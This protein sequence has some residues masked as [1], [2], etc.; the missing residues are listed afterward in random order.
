MARIQNLKIGRAKD[1]T[2]GWRQPRAARIAERSRDISLLKV[3][4][5]TEI[6]KGPLDGRVAV[7]TGARRG[8]GKAI[9]L[10]LSSAGAKVAL[11]DRD[12][13]GLSGVADEMTRTG[14][15]AQSFQ[16]DV[17]DEDQVSRAKAEVMARFGHVDIL[18]NNAGVII[19]KPLEEFSLEEWER[20]LTTNLTSV[21]L[22][23]RAFIPQMK[24]RG[25]GRILNMTSTMSHVSI[26]GRTAYSASKAGML[27]LTK[28]LALE[29]ASE[30]ITVVG[31]SPG[32]F[33]T[34]INMASIQDPA[35]SSEFLSRIPIGRWGTPEEVGQLARYLC[36]PEASYIT[37]TDILIDGGWTAQ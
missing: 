11:I 21:F 10:S 27:G 33:A 23:C 35:I 1:R 29:L 5:M 16:A 25:Y 6:D 7:I 22:M 20:V 28:A 15:E 17:T 9:A 3:D 24:G 30:G 19:R 4:N 18:V 26:A 31:I 2:S 12:L 36:S 32:I 37:G 13:E 8:L 14:A 34:E